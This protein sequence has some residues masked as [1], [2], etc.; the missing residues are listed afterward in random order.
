MVPENEKKRRR[1]LSIP[2]W[3]L[4]SVIAVAAP[5]NPSTPGPWL[6]FDVA[7]GMGI[8]VSYT[9]VNGARFRVDIAPK[10]GVFTTRWSMVYG[11][12]NRWYPMALDLREYA[13]QTIRVRLISEHLE[14]R[15]CQDYPF[16]GDP[17]L[18]VGDV[19]TG[20]EI[21]VLDRLALRRPDRVGQ[22]LPD[23]R[24]ATFTEP[25]LF[26]GYQGVE[27]VTPGLC[28]TTHHGMVYGGKAYI[29][30]TGKSQP[31]MYIGFDM[32]HGFG[33]GPSED[34]ALIEKFRAAYVGEAEFHENRGIDAA[35][36]YRG[37]NIPP[38]FA[39]W[40]VDV[41][42]AAAGAMTNQ[43]VT[44]T[45]LPPASGALPPLSMR[46]DVYR[47][48][49]GW[50]ARFDATA[51]VWRA[52]SGS[53]NAPGWAFAAVE[54]LGNREL[55][56]TLTQEGALTPTGQNAF[57]GIV[58][59]YRTP[60]G[61][62]KR[63][64]LALDP[65]LAAP[66]DD[67]RPGGWILDDASFSLK[68]R[69]NF[70]ETYAVIT[71]G[72]VKVKL[73]DYAPADWDGRFV[74]ALGMQNIAP[75]AKL[76]MKLDTA[77]A[78]AVNPPVTSLAA[79]E[80][81]KKDFVVLRDATTAIAVSRHNGALCGAWDAVSGEAWL[82][83]AA[84]NYKLES[85]YTISEA[86]ELL[87]AVQTIE[88]RNR[89]R[90]LVLTCTT[91]ALPGV[92]LT[93]RYR[94]GDDGRWFKQLEATLAESGD[95]SFFRWSNN[96]GLAETV[97]ATARRGAGFGPARR[98]AQGK[99]IT[100]SDDAPPAEQAGLERPAM[101]T[102]A[103]YSNG[104]GA[105]R[106]RVNNR[107]VLLGMCNYRPDGWE[108][109]VFCDY[110]AP[111][112]TVSGEVAYERYN[113]DFSNLLL[114]YQNQPE[115]RELYELTPPDWMRMLVCDSM[116]TEAQ[117]IPIGV[118]VAPF[119]TSSCIWW[120]GFPWGN[121]GGDHLDPC[122]NGKH[123]DA[124]NIAVDYRQQMPKHRMSAYHNFLFDEA[125]DIFRT[126]PQMGVRDRDGNLMS[127]GISSDTTHGPAFMLQAANPEVRAFMSRM[128]AD[129]VAQWSFDYLYFDG[130]GFGLEV[131]DWGY[132]DV[133]QSYDWIDYLRA[134][135]AEIKKL[136]NDQLIFCNGMMPFAQLGYI[137]YRDAQWLELAGSKW[138]PLASELWQQKLTEPKGFLRVPTYGWMKAEPALSAYL[139]L[140]G[141]LGNFS[142]VRRAPW[143][144]AS[145]E[146]HYGR[147]Q[148]SA[149]SPN[150]LREGGDV[151]AYGFLHDG[152]GWVTALSHA[153]R[154]TPAALRVQ[155]TD[156]GLTPGRRLYGWRW[157]ME[158]PNAARPAPA[159]GATPEQLRAEA[160]RPVMHLAALDLPKTA[161]ATLT[162]APTL[163]PM[164]TNVIFLSHAPVLIAAVDGVPRQMGISH[165]LV[166]VENADTPDGALKVVVL[167]RAG[168]VLLALPGVTAE[169]VR[170]VTP[171]KHELANGEWQGTAAARLRIGTGRYEF[172]INP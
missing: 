139:V 6:R 9:E 65:A 82:K 29:T 83:E 61:Y 164:A 22:L 56:L 140:Y 68:Q 7:P 153:P 135:R 102:K 5:V 57:A 96:S 46:R 12:L 92:T 121:Y 70:T 152:L 66:R 58:V 143:M 75:G 101:V 40:T 159:A 130:P 85:R 158:H 48:Q 28:S 21:K 78:R 107:F 42:S 41:P 106:T 147:L 67:R 2:V 63:V 122:R 20:E 97:S 50:D 76:E 112:K 162:V 4:L 24:V 14:N 163:A 13:G 117:T 69:L 95:G 172:V 37:P 43:A 47:F 125:S 38:T 17:R 26:F 8:G 150:W 151:E 71:P 144:L 45:T 114:R 108:L 35:F 169:H 15:L 32:S 98:V 73:A 23:G 129:Q 94:F 126:R 100:E 99:V 84:D 36:P 113:G 79:A 103:D 91:P 138:Q 81:A 87:D 39:E 93:K 111:G 104:I 166:R 165:P 120:L 11:N 171:R 148:R 25:A 167:N 161:P 59:D 3:A 133:A 74:L 89:G 1:W 110:L 30:V 18:G 72:T 51:F 131:P 54:S 105:Y 157:E 118:G 49:P 149:V 115:F 156:L 90:E 109:F 16:W 80:A 124:W 119:G 154:V 52:R 146:L 132:L 34:R 64:W 134:T 19:K 77:G 168:S 123:P 127:S 128:Y 31:G 136:G 44:A 53:R 86:T 155:L 141:W 137:E 27:L 170:M 10:T 116:F 160:Q 88:W 55:A 145:H 62:Q 33:G 142:D 60:L